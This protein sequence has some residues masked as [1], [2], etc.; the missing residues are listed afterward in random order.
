MNFCLPKPHICQILF[1]L[2][3][4]SVVF[5][6]ARN[7]CVS[8]LHIHQSWTSVLFFCLCYCFNC[9]H[10]GLAIGKPVWHRAFSMAIAEHWDGLELTFFFHPSPQN[11]C[12]GGAVAPSEQL[13]LL[14][15]TAAEVC[16]TNMF[17]ISQAHCAAVLGLHNSWTVF[18]FPHPC[19]STHVVTSELHEFL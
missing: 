1:G 9:V 7:G 16:F 8:R 5:H 18:P 3:I 14:G 4:L 10:S 19:F 15:I 17:Y 13:L 11:A 12:A 2:S 6:C